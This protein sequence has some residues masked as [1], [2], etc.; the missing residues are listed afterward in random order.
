MS[1]KHILVLVP[2]KASLHSDIWDK[3]KQGYG[4]N[5]ITTEVE[6]DPPPTKPYA[7]FW[8]FKKVTKFD[9][10]KYIYCSSYIFCKY[11]L[12]ILVQMLSQHLLYNPS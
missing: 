12:Y 5:S 3:N 10:W 11:H 6:K 9:L 7:I 1:P 2:V 4:K 8:K